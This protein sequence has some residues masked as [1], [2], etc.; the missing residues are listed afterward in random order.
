MEQN[1]TLTGRV[2]LSRKEISTAI[3]EWLGK[4]K[5][6]QSKRFVYEIDENK[7]KGVVVDVYQELGTDDVPEI[8][9]KLETKKEP[10]KR[11]ARAGFT[12]K[13]VGIFRHLRELFDEQKKEGNLTMDFETIFEDV[14]NHFPTMNRTK[15]NVYLHDRRQLPNI[16]YS[17]KAKEVNLNP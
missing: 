10:Q 14:K 1:L 17:S 8:G 11:N 6:L 9:G 15:L 4:T 16:K 3:N 7:M 12:R 13:N 2:R 5:K